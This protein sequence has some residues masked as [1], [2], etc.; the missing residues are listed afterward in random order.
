MKSEDF[1]EEQLDSESVFRGKLLH[2]KR[3]RVRLPNGAE[4]TREYIVHPGAVVI[5]PVFDNRDVILV[6]QFRYPL[7]RHFL[8][9]PAGKIDPGEDA[10]TCG[11]REL[12]EEAG[13]GAGKWR[14]VTTI[15]P[16]IGYSDERLVYYLAEDLEFQGRMPDNDEFLEVLRMP[17]ES[18][19]AMVGTNEICEAKTVAGLFWLEK[20]MAGVWD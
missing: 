6:R 17:L 9:F 8:E 1:S 11:R 20:R 16:C 18:A 19:L 7:G 15:Y 2:V 4:S 12:R 13:Y 10:E 5:M 3:D 14:Y